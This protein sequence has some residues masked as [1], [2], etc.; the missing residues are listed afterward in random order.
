VSGLHHVELRP[1]SLRYYTTER[2]QRLCRK[3]TQRR[4][5]RAKY[6]VL[7]AA[8]PLYPQKRFDHLVRNGEHVC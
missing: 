5:S 1:R 8:C 7:S 6:P 4:H 2:P 3:Q